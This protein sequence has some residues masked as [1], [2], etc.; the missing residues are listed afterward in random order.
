MQ[1]V[2]AV[3]GFGIKEYQVVF[4]SAGSGVFDP[5]AGFLRLRCEDKSAHLGSVKKCVGELLA[6]RAAFARARRAAD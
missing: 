1:R 5:V 4:S 6:A 3:A 2:E